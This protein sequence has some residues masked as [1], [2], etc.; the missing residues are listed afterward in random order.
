MFSHINGLTE[1][2]PIPVPVNI[3][4]QFPFRRL[5][6]EGHLADVQTLV[7]GHLKQTD[8]KWVFE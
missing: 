2:K 7:V 8:P 6:T 1:L 3:L 5:G 4:H